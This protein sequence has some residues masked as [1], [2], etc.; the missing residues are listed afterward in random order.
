MDITV[1][2]AAANW[3]A[4]N[5]TDLLGRP[6]GRITG[7]G[8]RFVIEPDDRVRASLIG[9]KWGPYASLDEALTAIEKHTHGA[10]HRASEKD[11]RQP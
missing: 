7:A 11:E 3:M 9:L 8:H 10:C 6:V 2:R 4:W 1:T 5:L